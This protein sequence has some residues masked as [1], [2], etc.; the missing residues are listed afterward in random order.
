MISVYVYGLDQFL[1]GDLSRE[2]TKNLADVLEVSEDD[3]NFVAPNDMIFH[4][5]VEQTSW[6]VLVEVKLP[7][8]YTKLQNKVKEVLF[9]Y[10]CEV[11]VHVEITFNYYF[12]DEHYIKINDKYPLYLDE[13]ERVEEETYSEEMTEGE[14][15]DEIYTGDI[16]E[17][18]IDK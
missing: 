1:V 17:G 7:D 3:I 13:D 11:A 10:I 18:V 8:I 5:G 16:F 15:E 2:V 14:G 4:K 9:H 12:N 6:R